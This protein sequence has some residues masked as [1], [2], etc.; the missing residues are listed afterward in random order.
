MAARWADWT[1]VLSAEHLVA[2][3]ARRSAAASVCCW[4]VPKDAC[5]VGRTDSHL[6]EWMVASLAAKMAGQKDSQ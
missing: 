4:A 3:L 6:A 5:S 1:V 2:L